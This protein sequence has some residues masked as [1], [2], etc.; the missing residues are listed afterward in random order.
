VPHATEDKGSFWWRDVLKLCDNFRGIAKCLVGTDIWNDLLLQ[1]KF[2]R[3]YSFAKNKNIFAEQ[4]LMHNHIGEQFHMP[5]L[6]RPSKKISKCSRLFSNYR[7]LKTVRTLLG[8]RREDRKETPTKLHPAHPTFAN[9]MTVNTFGVCFAE[10]DSPAQRWRTL[11]LCQ[12]HDRQHLRHLFCRKSR[13]L[14]G[15]AQARSE[16]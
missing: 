4:F 5:C 16:A 3:L 7:F 2:P 15:E 12:H 9:I 13:P 10:R 6:D 11:D 1:H 8:T 14:N